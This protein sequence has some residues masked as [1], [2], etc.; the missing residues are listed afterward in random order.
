MRERKELEKVAKKFNKVLKHLS[1]R[2]FLQIMCGSTTKASP[3]FD[4]NRSFNVYKI[5]KTDEGNKFRMERY[6]WE[7]ETQSFSDKPLVYEHTFAGER[8]LIS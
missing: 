5:E 6:T 1:S 3:N 2:P 4:R 7:T 8:I